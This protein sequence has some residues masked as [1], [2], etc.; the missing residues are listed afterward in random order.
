[1]SSNPISDFQFEDDTSVIKIGL[2]LSELASAT[3]WRAKLVRTGL[4]NYFWQIWYLTSKFHWTSRFDKATYNTTRGACFAFSFFSLTWPLAHKNGNSSPSQ[5][6]LKSPHLF[7]SHYS[8]KFLE[9]LELRC[10]S[11]FWRDICYF[12]GLFLGGFCADLGSW[13]LK[14]W[15]TENLLKKLKVASKKIV[16]NCGVTFS[17]FW[18]WQKG[19]G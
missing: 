4:R 5:T 17:Y 10:L 2:S 14:R 1:M 11:G 16:K 8:F 19:F 9:Y 3:G 18:R 12:A 6:Y 7:H 13:W 15:A